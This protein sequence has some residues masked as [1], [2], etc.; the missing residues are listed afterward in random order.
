MVSIASEVA[1][2]I[3]AI[4]I[5]PARINFSKSTIE[6]PEQCVKSVEV[7]IKVTFSLQLYLK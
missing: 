4:R 2:S 6:V 1:E 3:F 7:N 5:Y